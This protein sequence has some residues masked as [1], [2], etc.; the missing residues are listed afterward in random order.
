MEE[1]PGKGK[2]LSH[3]AHANGMHEMTYSAENVEGWVTGTVQHSGTDCVTGTVQHSGTDC[4]TGTVQH[5]GTDCVTGT[6]QHS[7]TDCVT[8]TEIPNIPTQLHDDYWKKK[9]TGPLIPT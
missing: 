1:V 3:S 5:S 6:V 8:N 4:V 2:E 7:G 9:T